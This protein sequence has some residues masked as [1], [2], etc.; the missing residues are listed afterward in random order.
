M[1]S[2]DVSTGKSSGT[3]HIKTI[4]SFSPTTDKYPIGNELCSFDDSVMQLIYIYIYIYLAPFHYKQCLLQTPRRKI[5]RRDLTQSSVLH[6][7][8][9]SVTSHRRSLK[10]RKRT[11]NFVINLDT[12]A[13]S[14]FDSLSNYRPLA[15][16]AQEICTSLTLRRQHCDD[17][18][19]PYWY[20]SSRN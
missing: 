14:W 10:K 18:R 1:C 12:I 17:L 11:G 13:S 15:V 16:T 8:Q 9:R 4:L 20:G 19:P 3:T 7:N 6:H 5:H 2:I